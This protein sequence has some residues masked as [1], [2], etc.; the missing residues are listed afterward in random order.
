MCI[1]PELP[2]QEKE[3]LR[4]ALTKC[5]YPKWA[6]DKVEKDLTG[7]PVRSLMGSTTRVPTVSLLPPKKLRVRGTVIPYTQGLCE[8]VKKICGRYGIQTHFKGGSTIKN[9]LISPK[10]KDP[11][12]PKVMPSIGINVGTLLVM[13]N[14]KGKL[15]GPLV[16]DTKNT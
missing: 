5:K 4:R 3:H 12:S 8:S 15:L 9:L 2:K 7:L 10:D 1:N 11:W 13:M 16:K 14:T 6:L